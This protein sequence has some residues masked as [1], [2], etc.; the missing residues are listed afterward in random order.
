MTL[1]FLKMKMVSA[2]E[3]VKGRALGFRSP[4]TGCRRGK[5]RPGTENGPYANHETALMSPIISR[6]RTPEES[7]FSSRYSAVPA[8]GNH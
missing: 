3:V 7:A 4:Q 8:G 2:S 6:M 1:A 5:D